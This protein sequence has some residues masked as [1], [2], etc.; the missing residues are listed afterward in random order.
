MAGGMP[1]IQAQELA[2]AAADVIETAAAAGTKMR[3][4]GGVAVYQLS[5]AARQPPLARQYHDFDVVVP[6]GRGRSAATVFR[7]SGYTE[8]AHFNALHGARRMI[9]AN[10][11]GFVVDLLIGTFQMCHELKLGHD[12]PDAGLTVHPADLMLTKLQIV[13]I[14]DKDLRDATALLL[15]LPVG[16]SPAGIQL[17]RFTAPLAGDWGFFHTI[18]KNL[19]KVASYAAAQLQAP[20]AEH[21]AQSVAQLKDAMDRAP[22]SLRWKARSRIGERTPWYDLP[23]EV[24]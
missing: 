6:P 2:A 5:Q 24:E 18:E 13:Q 17:R 21:V 9:F 10:P 14:E 7:D 23:E 3:L 16:D 19:P 1:D 15:D 22:K 8:D 4:L 11:A 12:L 20:G